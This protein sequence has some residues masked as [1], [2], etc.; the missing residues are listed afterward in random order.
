MGAFLRYLRDHPWQRRALTGSLA[1]LVGLLTALLVTP[2]ARDWLLL[3]D[4][5]SDNPRVRARA[6]QRA[7]QRAAES[8]A[9]L[10]RLKQALD[11]P[12]EQLFHAV[13]G[14]LTALGRLDDPDVPPRYL[15]RRDAI[16]LAGAARLDP[17][18]RAERRIPL[19]RQA[20][21]S[22]RDNEYLRRMARLASLDEP[23]HPDELAVLE[24]A[25]LLAGRLGDDW[26]LARLIQ[27]RQTD[28]EAPHDSTRGDPNARPVVRAILAAGFAGR[29]SLAP[30]IETHLRADDLDVRS[31]SAVALATLAPNRYGETLALRLA[32]SGRNT[33]LRRRLLHV[34]LLLGDD[35][36]RR[37]VAGLAAE[38]LA[39]ASP[40]DGMLL[41]AAGR[42]GASVPAVEALVRRTLRTAA[43]PNAG[44]T[45]AQLLG[46]LTASRRLGLATYEPVE[47]VFRELWSPAAAVAMSAAARALAVIPGGGASDQL[48]ERRMGVLT[49]A[50]RF[51]RIEVS[52]EGPGVARVTRVT[53]PLASAEAAAGLWAL[54]PVDG[55]VEVRAVAQLARPLAGDHVA[56][57]LSRIDPDA[58]FPLGLRMCPPPFDPT[59]E[60]E[61][62]SRRVFNDNER[63]AGAMLLALSARGDER[64][65]AAIERI[66]ARLEGV[67]FGGEDH[68]F[69]RGAMRC[70]LVILDAEEDP[71]GQDPGAT[72]DAAVRL[73][74]IGEFPRR[75]V[76]TAL[77][78]RGDRAALDWLL[79]NPDVPSADAIRW[80]LHDDLVGVLEELAPA[81][82][83][84]TGAGGDRLVEWQLDLLSAQYAVQ[85]DRLEMGD[86]R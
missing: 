23:D 86:R 7:A 5:A 35:R 68:P 28:A 54:S 82:G 52:D 9:T 43:D 85:R 2:V 65:A 62:A 38:S 60:G 20:L 3:R 15:D 77:L 31:A 16:L 76:I 74:G 75:R 1:V 64:R 26:T 19:L 39:E 79:W 6:I 42:L 83:P 51:V 30:L 11:T 50:A 80:L 8:P 78:T 72:R 36:A 59:A 13:A 29:A 47:R 48:R 21:L 33:P 25:A 61:P 56:W 12:D 57:R 58:A 55:A 53:M 45:Q 66:R 10:A 41:E 49:D 14:A 22:G 63:S 67:G 40:P 27:W 73:L 17:R 34:M 44:V 71:A 37:A 24:L 69:V 81:L 32:S 84:V 46:A 70:A 18:A 4:L